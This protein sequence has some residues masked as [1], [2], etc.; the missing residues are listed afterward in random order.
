MEIGL[1]SLSLLDRT[2]DE[3]LD[4]LAAN[5]ITWIEA[6]AGGHI[7]KDHYDPHALLADPDALARFRESLESRGL[8]I[9]A[10]GCYGNPVHP[11]AERRQRDHD[12]FAATC[13]LARELGVDRVTVL[14]GCPAGGPTDRAPNWIVN[15][16]YP[17]FRSAYTWQW[18]K[19][20][21]PYWREA[22]ALADESGVRICIEPHGG[23][24]VYNHETFLRLR[25]AI[26]PTVG[27]NFDP[28][29]LFWMGIDV[30]AMVHELGDA[31]YY[32]HAKDVSI[33]EA[34][35]R[36]EGLV[37]AVDFADWGN[38]SWVYRAVGSGHGLTFWR[39]LLTCLRRVGYD[40]V[41]SLELEDP[42]LAMD[43]TIELSLTTLRAA[44]PTRPSPEGNWFDAY[45]WEGAEVE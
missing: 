8:R 19:C 23:D 27:V 2:W 16:I 7:P 1:C 42:F 25:D 5:G 10:F 41:V 38:R 33:D 12:D 30:F 17:D 35:V 4:T 18:E 39:E 9:A 31:I 29:H 21:I 3:A 20:L 26:G 11:S 13:R 40:G 34:A 6:D 43:D 15:S 45:K 36:R 37:P 44:M 32:V 14:S 28:S 24:M 22:A